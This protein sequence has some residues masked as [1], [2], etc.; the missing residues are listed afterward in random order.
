MDTFDDFKEY[1]HI[2]RDDDLL[3]ILKDEIIYSDTISEP[4]KA[5]SYLYSAKYEGYGNKGKL[6]QRGESASH[7]G[8]YR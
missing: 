4:N 7:P 8:V 5:D 2:V 3:F 6:Y 1:M